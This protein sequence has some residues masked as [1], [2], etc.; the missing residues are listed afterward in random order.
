MHQI[1]NHPRSIL[2]RE[3]QC[4]GSEVLPGEMGEEEIVGDVRAMRTETVE[5]LISVSG[6][7]MGW[8]RDD[9]NICLVDV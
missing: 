9:S 5:D 7:M 3:Q 8:R 6:K 4:P 2:P 1:C